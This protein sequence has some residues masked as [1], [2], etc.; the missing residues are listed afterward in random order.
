VR[1]AAWASLSGGLYGGVILVGFAL[2]LGA[3]PLAIGLL[4]A[5][6]FLAQLAQL[7][8]VSLIERWRRRRELTVLASIGSR[9]LVAALA[10]VPFVDPGA[11]LALLLAAQ[12]A[13]ALLGSVA[14]CSFN[15]WLHQLLAGRELGALFARRLVWST[16]L[17]SGGALLS[18]TLVEHGPLAGMLQAYSLAF[19][20]AALA[21]LASSWYL[22]QVPEPPMA[23][24]GPPQ[25]LRA[26][27]GAALR[28]PRFRPVVI[29][30]GAWNFAA[31]LAA[32]R[33]TCAWRRSPRFGRRARSRTRSR[34]TCGGGSPT[35]C[36]TR[37]S[38]RSRCP[39]T[40]A[41]WW[42]CRSPRCPR[43]TR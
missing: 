37:R 27:L 7:P 16:L 19:A 41:A 23:R 10:L 43:F 5:I 21:G 12:L 35:A 30:M 2:Q 32:S 39:R 15:S 29:F 20:A 31:T 9:L 22:A 8:A 26:M 18:G 40:S 6:P 4:A 3:G 1:D 36:R 24:T 34:S 42:R 14:G 28:D 33:W 11:Q 25:P 38:W 13:I 17:A